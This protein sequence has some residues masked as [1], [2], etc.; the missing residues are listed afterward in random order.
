LLAAKDLAVSASGSGM[1]DRMEKTGQGEAGSIGGVSV[2]PAPL[3]W[4]PTRLKRIGR[5][6]MLNG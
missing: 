2:P 6:P 5:G 1:G 3:E 4:G